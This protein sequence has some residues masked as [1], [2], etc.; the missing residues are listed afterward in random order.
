MGF[1]SANFDAP[2]TA[3]FAETGEK[4]SFDALLG[5][6]FWVVALALAAILAGGLVLLESLTSWRAEAGADHDGMMAPGEAPSA[7]TSLG[8]SAKGVR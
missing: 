2:I 7:A 6:P 4:T 1:E 5:L 8:A 3:L